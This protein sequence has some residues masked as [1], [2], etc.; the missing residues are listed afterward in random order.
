MLGYFSNFNKIKPFELSRLNMEKFKIY[1]I[2]KPHL[3]FFG[4][5]QIGII[6]DSVIELQLPL[7]LASMVDNGIL[8]GDLKSI[9]NDG[10]IYIL[11]LLLNGLF[12]L[13]FGYFSAKA[14]NGFAADLRKKSFEHIHA[15]KISEIQKV[16]SAS[17]ITRLTSDIT[18]LQDSLNLVFRLG[19]RA[20]ILFVGG[21]F[22]LLFLDRSF[23]FTLCIA[24]VIQT[25]AVW[26]VLSKVQPLY[27][28]VQK[29]LDKL[30]VIS[31]E[32]ISGIKPIKS[33]ATA[34]NEKIK[35]ADISHDVSHNLFKVQR[36]ISLLQPI[37][38]IVMNITLA[39]LLYIGAVNVEKN[40]LE[41][42]QVM[43]AI[44]YLTQIIFALMMLAMIF[45]N[46]SKA[47]ISYMR[48]KE[49]FDLQAE[50]IL[51]EEKDILNDIQQI[52]FNNVTFRYPKNSDTDDSSL[53]I[54]ANINFSIKKGEKI[55]ILGATGSG[56]SSLAKLLF[57]IYEAEKGEIRVNGKPISDYKISQLR[58]EITYV[59]QKSNLF[60]T[61]IYEN[62]TFGDS[63]ISPEI[64]EKATK[65]ANAHDFISKLE[66][67]YDEQL[68]SKGVG[69]S[70][71]QKQRINLSRAFLK[72][73]SL[74]ILDD[75]TSALDM[76][77]EQE[78]Y[79]SI[80]ENNMHSMLI[81]ISQK[82]SSVKSMDKIYIMDKGKFVDSGT[83]D[84]LITSSI[85]YK[86]ICLSQG[87][88]E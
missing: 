34:T 65:I 2:I 67:L 47:K 86:K 78:V 64:V 66:N 14:S 17:L 71:G 55:A 6:L 58:K 83:H 31:Q 49:I 60:S 7:I 63:S 32:T 5:A 4:L 20:P 48:I 24:L 44:S 72:K 69:L 28:K 51:S 16:S 79:N 45:P 11:L 80:F 19:I 18:I 82:V 8:L 15:L 56:K 29:S 53:P 39:F 9:F 1:N 57:G 21:T 43:A 75:C 50:D 36:I 73:S 26:F 54:L 84:E 22:M 38:M 13:L 27:E 37:F 77:T 59:L 68:G 87:V 30:N 85:L 12:V 62:I 81:L 76:R 46:I 23:G 40:T 61:T 10:F 88:E 3:K 41:I 52:D 70:G 74:L 33:F 35:F 25:I 42:G